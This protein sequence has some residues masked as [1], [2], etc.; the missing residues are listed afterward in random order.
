[1]ANCN[2]CGKS[3]ECSKAMVLVG[4]RKFVQSPPNGRVF[5]GEAPS[6]RYWKT[7]ALISVCICPDC[8][9]KYKRRSFT[10]NLITLLGSLIYLVF[11]T[12]ISQPGSLEL[13]GFLAFLTAVLFF[14]AIIVLVISVIMFFINLSTYS[15]KNLKIGDIILSHY[16]KIIPKKDI[17]FQVDG[18]NEDIDLY[19]DTKIMDPYIGTL[20]NYELKLYGEE[21]IDKIGKQIDCAPV[22]GAEKAYD[23][24]KD[25]FDRIK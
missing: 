1:M 22:V 24:A 18:F 19:R 5:V 16:K 7:F 20:Y 9:K 13:E 14:V 2:F 4:Q 6:V 10:N 15:R 11:Y 8:I 17:L 3:V 12:L 23:D 25:L 21:E